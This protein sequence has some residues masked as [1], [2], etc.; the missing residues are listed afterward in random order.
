MLIAINRVRAI[1]LIAASAVLVS[2][3]G[4]GARLDMSFEGMPDSEIV[5]KSLNADNSERIIDTIK[6]DNFG[7]ARYFVELDEYSNPE[8]VS[9]Y[10]NG[11]MLAYVIAGDGEKINV[12]ADSSGFYGDSYSVSGSGESELLHKVEKEYAR[13]MHRYDSLKSA[14][15]ASESAGDH[16]L[17]NSIKYELGGLYVDAKRKATAYVMEHLGSFSSISVLFRYI[18]LE[19]PLFAEGSD[20]VYFRSLYDSLHLRYPESGFVS[21]LKEE[22]DRRLNMSLLSELL[23]E[24]GESGCPDLSLPDINSENVSLSSLKGKTV[25]LY[26]WSVNDVNQKMFNQE[27]KS[28][29]GK[30]EPEG[31]EIY[32]V[33]LDTDKTAWAS[34]V[35]IQK[36]PWINVC[37]G[38]GASSA[39]VSAYNVT[40]LPS[41]FLIDKSWTVVERDFFGSLEK[42]IEKYI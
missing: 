7:K 18:E 15:G 11:R 4:N 30:Y 39:A 21:L 13:M 31:L 22:A 29:Y 10:G 1:L 32:Q 33:C 16:A 14:L 23:S 24:A 8:F 27:L 6:T 2:C 37:D 38:L 26:F 28:V 12:K 9:V 35:R 17:S 5:L 34:A 20:A 19:L 41:I 36:L 25:V 40:A 3:S 42:T